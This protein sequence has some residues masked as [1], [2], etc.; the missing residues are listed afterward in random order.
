MT[1]VQQPRPDLRRPSRGPT[2]RPA[3]QQYRAPSRIRPNAHWP[4]SL[5]VLAALLSAYA[6]MHVVL[7]ELS[8][9]FVGGLFAAIV[10]AATT[11]TRFFTTSRWIPP[12][13]ALGASV[14]GVT[15]G[16]G[17]DT[18]WLGILPT[19]DTGDH[20]NAVINSGW[21]SIA[22]QRVPATPELGIV[23]LL[24]FLMIG[25]AFVADAAV[26]IIESPALMA[27]PLLTLLALPVAVRPDIA[28]PLW[29]LVTAILFL[30][31][32]RLGR[33]P[34]S[35]AVLGLMGS[36]VIG[37]S[38]LTP[39]FLPAVEEDSGPIGGGIATGINPLV[40]LGDDLRRG[41][42]VTAL[43]YTT[44]A[45]TGLYLRLA[46]LDTFNGRS[47]SPTMVETDRDNVVAEFPQPVGLADPVARE[48]LAAT[49]QVGEVSGRWLPLPY[50]S[51]TVTGLVGDWYW[52][53]NGLSARS[54]NAGV[55][56]QLYDVTFLDVQPN[57]DQ[58]RVSMPDPGGESPWLALPA[59]LP[60]VIGQ[61]A[62]E[63]TAGA[64]TSYD[65]AI[66]LQ[67]YFTDGTFQYSEDAPVEE[68]YDGTS[69]DILATF[70]EKKAGYCVHFASAMAVMARELGIPARMAVGFQPG[71]SST[72][73]GV[74]TYTVSS[75]DMHAWP[76][77]YFDGIG[78]LRF[79]PTPGRGI[80]PDYSAVPAVDD[81]LTPEDEGATPAPTSTTG[82]GAAPERPDE[83]GVDPGAGGLAGPAANPLPIVLASLG[84]ILLIGGI[85]PSVIRIVVRSRR[86]RAVRSG[87]DPAAAAWA[88][89]RDTARDYGWAAPESETPRDFADR[90][91]VVMQSD[92]EAIAGLRSDV[93]ESAFAPP[94]RGVPSVGELRAVRKAIAR[95]VDRRDRLRA[96]F[97]PASLL[98]RFRWDPEG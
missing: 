51:R 47:W 57:I 81:P 16:F 58:V 77:L 79:E 4:R 54:G 31:V 29:F 86:L 63:V 27:P 9:W 50:P 66:A 78:W 55:R 40:N 73:T 34:A 82:P 60:E 46:T 95:T 76:E 69:G 94:G 30:I 12:L 68:G 75:H 14:L 18:P 67:T 24:V 93:E 22:E 17:G 10:L 56:G 52:E 90:L 33:R 25:S 39:T 32:L 38:L 21:Q 87:R 42:P 41:D 45:G 62:Q 35:T 97:M 64:E 91:A 70:L 6:G 65:K 96:I 43:T 23:L 3:V 48:T 44:N 15:I 88:E 84:A 80:T 98:A 13:V 1:T 92:K 19:F 85:A 8:W 74:T 2:G 61:T 5:L 26:S 49:V 7:Q 28:D 83:Q 37:G 36:I 20:I 11:I 72:L 89:L 53:A 71:N 59:R